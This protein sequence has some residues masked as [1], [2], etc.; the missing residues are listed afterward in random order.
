MWIEEPFLPFRKV[1]VNFPLSH[2]L[3][4]ASPKKGGGREGTGMRE[5]AVKEIVWRDLTAA[6]QYDADTIIL[7]ELGILGGEARVDIAVINGELIGYEIKSARDNLQRL[8]RQ[9]EFYNSV[10]DR[11]ILVVD[12]RH[13]AGALQLLPEWWGVKGIFGSRL[14]S[15]REGGCNQDVDAWSLCWLLWR[16][17]ALEILNRHGLSQ[18]MKSKP[19][20]VLFD[21]LAKSLPLTTLKLEVRQALKRRKG[22]REDNVFR[23]GDGLQDRQPTS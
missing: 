11:V 23:G 15:V 12:E 13:M 17:E 14:E 21:R 22:W 1:Y 18:G 5:H 4:S 8:P 7:E 6:Y 16:E 2:W 3:S 19:K 10:F 9:I 20:R